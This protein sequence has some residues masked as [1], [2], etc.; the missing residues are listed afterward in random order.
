MSAT[1]VVLLVAAF[2]L[3]VLGGII[4]VRQWFERRSK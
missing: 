2:C 3:V 4:A 1:V